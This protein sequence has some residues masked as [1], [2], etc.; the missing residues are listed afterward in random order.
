MSTWGGLRVNGIQI[1]RLREGCPPELLAAFT[2]DSLNIHSVAANEAYGE[3]YGEEIIEVARLSAPGRAVAQRLDM[4][5]FTAPLARDHLAECIEDDRERNENLDP[6]H[7]PYALDATYL[8][9]YSVDDWI[10][11]FK[12]GGPSPEE[13]GMDGMRWIVRHIDYMDERVA[14][15]TALLAVPDAQV[16]VDLDFIEEP[17]HE[18]ELATLCST[19]LNGLREEGAAH[20]PVVVLTE[21]KTDVEILRPSLELLA[22]HLVDFIKFMDYGGRPP[23]G[24][25]ILVNTVRAFAAAGIANR[26]VAIFDNDTAASD[27]IRK[28]DQGKLPNNI[29]VR[30]Y[31]PLEI[32]AR[33]PTL[34][35]PTEDSLKG[36]I[37]LADVNGL[38]GSIEL[39][40][41]RDVLERPDGILSPVQWKSYIEGSRSYQGE[42]MG[43][44]QLQEKF[45]AKMDAALRDKS[46]L[47]SQ[48]WSGIQAIIDVI[49]TAFD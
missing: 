8:L 36:Q 16:T 46:V 32:A 7:K 48:D 41:G 49:I 11:D 5:G 21:G 24:A 45:K 40:L 43:K 17:E 1:N 27:A 13:V 42:V 34:G 12:A 19:S 35:P 14:L 22:P 37:S 30:Q 3:E 2:D 26:V 9:N 31:P 15:R 39:Y 20:A 18:P 44:A 4:M 29:Q 28:L 10:E 6:E 23:G 47:E 38:A 33:Y 25:S